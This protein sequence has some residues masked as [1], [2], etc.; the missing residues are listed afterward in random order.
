M[1]FDFILKVKLFIIL[2]PFIG[3]FIFGCIGFILG[4]L[5]IKAKG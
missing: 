3:I 5:I 2:N 4:V 1:I